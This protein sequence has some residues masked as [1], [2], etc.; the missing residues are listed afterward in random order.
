MKI[1]LLSKF[2]ETDE[3]VLQF[4]EKLAQ[5]QE[6]EI[7]VLHVINAYSEV[8]LKDDGTIIDHCVDFDL[9]SLLK[10]KQAMETLCEDWRSRSSHISRSS[11][12]IG[13][14]Q[15]VV[16][17]KLKHQS[18]DAVFMGAHPTN[19][20]EDL[21]RNTTIER[22]MGVSEIPVLSLK[23]DRSNEK[24]IER[25]GVFNDF[26][27]EEPKEIKL[28]SAIA[29]AFDAE[30]HLYKILNDS[31][32]VNMYEM[33]ERMN[34]FAAKNKLEKVSHHVLNEK[35][36]EEEQMNRHLLTE[37][38]NLVVVPEIHRKS[39]SWI[40]PKDLKTAL[41]NHLFAPLIIY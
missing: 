17:Y 24:V 15:K 32:E 31:L 40:Y 35:G 21:I 18:F 30:V 9:T 22:I 41:A 34:A 19:F 25:I 26:D 14:L 28:V 12:E 11:V 16:E 6:V 8:P 38:L 3:F 29:R 37:K 7:E 4:A 2:S 20:L 23:C 36:S 10:R 5:K 39:M 13:H 27:G 1:L 33:E